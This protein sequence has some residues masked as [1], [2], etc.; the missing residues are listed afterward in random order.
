MLCC[1]VFNTV[2]MFVNYIQGLDYEDMSQRFMN[3]TIKVNDEKESH[4]DYAY[5]EI[6]LTDYND[7]PP[8]FKIKHQTKRLKEDVQP[9]TSLVKVEATDADSGDNGK[10][11]C[12]SELMNF[13]A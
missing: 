2:I 5:V 12:S 10:F 7:N 9:G 8:D 3:L 11:R 13:N 6:I 1:S 4:Y